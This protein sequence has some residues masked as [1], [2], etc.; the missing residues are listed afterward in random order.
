MKFFLNVLNLTILLLV[1]K[2]N[3][4]FDCIIL[5]IFL[6]LN[7]LQCKVNDLFM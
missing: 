2:S 5:S 1:E 6:T 7:L 3:T 4:A